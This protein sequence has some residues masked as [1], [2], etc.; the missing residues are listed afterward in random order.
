MG[1]TLVKFEHLLIDTLA[2]SK[3]VCLMMGTMNYY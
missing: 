3:L 1:K 2:L